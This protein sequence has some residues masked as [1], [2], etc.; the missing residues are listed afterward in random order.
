LNEYETSPVVVL[1]R[2]FYTLFQANG[3]TPKSGSPADVEI[4]SFSRSESVRTAFSQAGIILEAAADHLRALDTLVNA[5][6]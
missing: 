6:D 2:D 5:K 1:L 3:P 4:R